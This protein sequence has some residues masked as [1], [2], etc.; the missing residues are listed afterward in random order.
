MSSASIR[1]AM[2]LNSSRSERT[3][4]IGQVV[5]QIDSFAAS[6]GKYLRRNPFARAGFI[7]Y[8]MLIHLWTF[9]LLFFHAHSFDTLPTGSSIGYNSHGPH[10]LIQQQEVLKN[11]EL[12][13][14]ADASAAV[15]KKPS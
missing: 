9:V 15:L 2:L 12:R 8:L 13:I 7:F 4:K 10:A 3:E 5:D 6:T 11:A 1:T 14:N